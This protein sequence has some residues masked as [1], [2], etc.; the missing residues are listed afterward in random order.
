MVEGQFHHN[1]VKINEGITFSNPIVSG[2]ITIHMSSEPME[3]HYTTYMRFI[4]E[5]IKLL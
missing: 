3:G 5:Q 1:L 4:N 2:K